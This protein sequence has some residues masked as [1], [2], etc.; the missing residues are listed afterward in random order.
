[1]TDKDIDQLVCEAKKSLTVDE[2]KEAIRKCTCGGPI[3]QSQ[4]KRMVAQIGGDMQYGKT[5]P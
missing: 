4:Y 2:I 5:N 1:M 3:T